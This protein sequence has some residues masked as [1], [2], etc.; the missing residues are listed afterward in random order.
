MRRSGYARLTLLGALV[1]AP[2]AIAQAGTVR[3][4]VMNGTTGKPAPGIELT[5]VQL[6]GGMQE[7]AHSKSDAQGEFTF[8][9][10]ALGAQPML[11]RAVYHGVIFNHAVPPGTSTAQVDIYESTK[12]AKTINVPS[13]VV[14]FQPNGTTM[15][16]GE[17]YQIENKSQPPVAFYKT[18]GSFDFTLPEGGQL[19]QVSAAG[20]AGMPVVQLPIDKKKNR[21]A[22]AFAFRPGDSS[23]RLSY[24]LPYTGNSATVKIPT[25]YP[26]ARLL[27]VAPPSVQ[28]SGDELAPGGQEQG[29]NLY[30]RRDVP[31]GTLVTVNVSGTAP[32]S[33][34]NAGA[35]QGQ[36]GRDAQQGGG[37][38]G[39]VSIQ[40]VPGRLDGLKWYLVVGFL[41]LFA[42]GAIL[43]GRKT[44]VAVA[45]GAAAEEVP[46][47]KQKKVKPGN[48]PAV[49]HTAPSPAPASTA[50]TTNG[51]SSL[52]EVDAAIGTSLDALKERLFRLELRHQ[53][54]TIS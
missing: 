43:L 24:E 48:A 40:Q 21:Y 15:I 3:G 44:V 29:M 50:A 45:G 6:Q 30:G 16:V 49:A 5:L 51:E 32:P 4:T 54:G 20:P 23:V 42:M 14:I 10:P 41:G 1:L 19:Q 8:D 37:E 47:P 27:V 26:G 18:E 28:I 17:E 38:S 2:L 13:H 46:S 35:D 9:N 52:A 36:Q 7:L 12:D 34:A 25:I 53:A 22:I 33:D 31:A 11:V 39:G